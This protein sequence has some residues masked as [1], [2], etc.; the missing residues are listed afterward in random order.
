M[1]NKTIEKIWYGKVK[2]FEQ[3]RDDE[4][5]DTEVYK[6]V[7]VLRKELLATLTNEQKE[8][9]ERYESAQDAVTAICEKKSFERGF[10]LGVNLIIESVGKS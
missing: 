3:L 5:H 9:L 10:K 4:G 2:P 7:S 1:P 8:L 6:N